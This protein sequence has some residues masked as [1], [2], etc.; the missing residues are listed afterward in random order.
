[1]VSKLFKLIVGLSLM[2]AGTILALGMAETAFRL[3]LALTPTKSIPSDR[4]KYYFKAEKASTLQD[5]DLDPK[6]PDNAFRLAVIGD[7]YSYAPYMQF[8]DA[9]PK[10]LERML[11]LNDTEMRGEVINYG[12][13]AYST[14]HEIAVAEKAVREE[15]QVLL[16]QITLNDPEIKPIRPT[17]ITFFNTWGPLALTGWQRTI[18]DHWKSGFFVLSRLRNEKTRRAYIQYFLDLFNKEETWRNFARSVRKIAEIARTTNTPLVAVIFPL[19]GVPL[20]DS[21]PFHPCHQKAQALLAELK[22]ATL[23]LF[24]LYEGLPLERM[25]VIPNVDRHPNEIA[26]RMAAERIYDF[27]V[28]QNL[29]PSELVIRQRFKGRTQIIKEEVYP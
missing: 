29:V 2:T 24:D 1:M 5:Y 13:P 28:E 17:G 12:V 21:Y 3:V 27:L 4:P 22:V 7:S 18:F 16:L 19:F 15:S 20:D 23:D 26:H 6:R 8:T 25:Q 9:F 10:V 11:N 14:S